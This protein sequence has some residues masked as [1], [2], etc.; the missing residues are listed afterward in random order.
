MIKK[1]QKVNWD[2]YF[3]T[4]MYP[5]KTGW[6]KK[7][8]LLYRKWYVSWLNYINT[9]VPIYTPN[10][11]AFEFGSGIGAAASLLRDRGV[12][13]IGSD[14]SKKAVSI[15]KRL[16]P[17]VPFIT[18]DIERGNISGKTYDRVFA[19]EVLEHTNDLD[20]AICV[21]K[22]FLK[23][24]G[25]FVGTS[26]YPYQRNL[27]DPT[28]T[29]VLYPQQWQTLFEKNGF[30]TVN[31]RPMSCLPYVWK[32]HPLLHPILPFY[33]PLPFFVSTTLITARV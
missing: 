8:L 31:V 33:I 25:Y 11:T 14:I 22:K 1:I 20:A 15:A 27:K 2:T 10:L 7:T 3:G 26:P 13:I 24:G 9:L 18:C 19:F 21:I 6:H 23:K 32:F 12:A 29:H 4:C 16:S 30:R 28:H 17:S 5:S